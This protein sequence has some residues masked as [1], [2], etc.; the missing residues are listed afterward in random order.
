[1]WVVIAT[2][3]TWRAFVEAQ[4]K[5]IIFWSIL[6]FSLLNADTFIWIWW[7]FTN[8]QV[9]LCLLFCVGY[10]GI[11]KCQRTTKK[12]QTQHIPMFHV[13][14][15]QSC[16]LFEGVRNYVICKTETR[17]FLTPYQFIKGKQ[18]SCRPVNSFAGKL[19]RLIMFV[20]LVVLFLMFPGRAVSYELEDYDEDEEDFAMVCAK[21]KRF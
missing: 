19:N 14:I 9:G 16:T 4:Q 6:N 8:T 7:K 13:L 18:Y 5:T 21:M 12:T 20:S 3:V 15:W 2:L 1:M 17:R 10:S 11:R